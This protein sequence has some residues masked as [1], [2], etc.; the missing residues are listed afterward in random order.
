MERTI[1][2]MN[3]NC[4]EA[5]G[6]DLRVHRMI[7]QNSVIQYDLDEISQVERH[8][9]TI[10]RRSWQEVQGQI[11]N[12][13]LSLSRSLSFMFFNTLRKDR[14]YNGYHIQ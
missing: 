8:R 13:S 4:A 7:S 10:R 1:F 12:G 14:V 2:C 3:R 5:G 9:L 6:L 11:V